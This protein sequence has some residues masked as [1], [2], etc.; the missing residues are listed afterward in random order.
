MAVFGGLGRK[1]AVGQLEGRLSRLSWDH[2]MF[3][4]SPVPSTDIVC[5]ISAIMLKRLAIFAL[6]YALAT[7]GALASQTMPSNAPEKWIAT[8]DASKAGS[9]QAE[10][11]Q[12]N[13]NSPSLTSVNLQAPAAT[14]Q[15]EADTERETIDIQ[16][17]LE[18]FTGILALVGILQVGTM[19]WQ[20]WLLRG[21]LE[22][23]RVQAGHMGEQ[24]GIL[25]DSVAAAQTSADAA[26]AQIEMMK[27]KERAQ[28][29][30][31]FA[32]LYLKPDYKYV[33]YGGYP[34][35]FSVIMDGTTRAYILEENIV[36][37]IA[38]GEER[39]YR[40]GMGLPRNFTPEMSPFRGITYIQTNEF[41]PKIEA[42]EAKMRLVFDNKLF[43]EVQGSIYYR[44]LF[45]DH[46]SLTFR[47]FWKYNS[48]LTG[49]K[50]ATG[51][52]WEYGGGPGANEHK[53]V[54]RGGSCRK[55]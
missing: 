3:S 8:E 28:F 51:G 20:A 12:S 2:A 33:E 43:I 49:D 25:K 52:Y 50:N 22:Q 21:T 35:S 30:I 39:K 17:K 55:V 4:L 18:W 5:Y 26:A 19:I 9:H 6:F 24:T 11:Q 10:S 29:R 37:S 34:V 7:V 16:R 48:F 14:K 31:Q 54:N 42:D 45:G 53:Q 40:M 36:A 23:I 38:T 1:N 13:A 27:S 47:R 46:W 44:D 32:D 15:K 41:P